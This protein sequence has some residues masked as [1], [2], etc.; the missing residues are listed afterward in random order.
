[1]GLCSSD[2]SLPEPTT[3]KES[4]QL[5]VGREVPLSQIPSI[6]DNNLKTFLNGMRD[7]PGME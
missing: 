6:Y 3:D 7:T 1:M 4:S 2:N 5:S